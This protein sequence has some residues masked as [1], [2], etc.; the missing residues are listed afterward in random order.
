MKSRLPA[1]FMLTLVLLTLI[2]FLL[3]GFLSIRI[4]EARLLPAVESRTINS[5]LGLQQRLN[6]ALAFSGNL[7]SLRG[8]EETLDATR[9]FSPG[10]EF[11]ALTDPD[12]TILHLSANDPGSVAETLARL[13][14]PAPMAMADWLF[15]TWERITGRPL[16]SPVEMSGRRVGNLLLSSL[17]LGRDPGSPVGYL[18]AGVTIDVIDA[19]TR[20]I[21]FDIVTVVIAVAIVAIEILILIYAVLIIRPL[22]MID[23]LTKRLSVKDLRFVPAS[24]WGG[25][26]QELVRMINEVIWRGIDVA[27]TRAG[28]IGLLLPDADGPRPIQSPAVSYIRLPLFVFFLSE[29]ILRPIL[30]QFLGQFAPPDSDAGLRIGQIMAGFMA[31]SLISVL[32]G[33]ILAERYGV[34]RIFFCGALLSAAGIAGH[35][36]AQGFATI[37]L[38]R[39]LTGFGYGLVYAAAQIYIS[40]H[41]KLDR[42]SSGFSVFFA[43]VVA[44]EICGPAL[45]GVL[46]DRLGLASALMAATVVAAISALLCTLLIS[47][48]VPEL[49]DASGTPGDVAEREVEHAGEAKSNGDA[50]LVGQTNSRFARHVPGFQWDAFRTILLNPRFM[51][52]IVC[53]AI[54]SK[55]L[56]TGGLFFLMPLAVVASGGSA[57]DSARVIMAYG[58]AILLLAPIMSPLADRWPK[59][60]L[61]VAVGCCVAGIGLV[62]PHAWNTLGQGGLF[63]LMV[64]TLLFGVGQT[65][66]IPAQISYLMRVAETRG[67]ETSAGAVLGTYRFIE[68]LGSLFGPLVA[69]GLLLAST[70]EEAL[71]LMGIAAVLLMAF[72]LSWYL[73]FGDQEEGDAIRALLFET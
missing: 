65:L 2:P 5:G 67:S 33:S 27:K 13:T 18:H 72:G 36:A 26:M 16:F 58:I 10:M 19:L 45:G 20:D 54:P 70:P 49:T 62:L 63:V 46:A 28:E 31:A 3:F 47:R 39:S 7:E 21:W 24:L 50:A 1:L 34:R 59:Y 53:F 38:S 32:F 41:A 52:A 11:L 55:A 4:F 57:P 9:S 23:F 43:V 51:V 73:A 56:L 6:L 15:D 14:D 22:W 42:R 61:W 37:L 12:G 68:R 29:A 25:G 64:A 60:Y 8:V 35:L 30:P 44:A 66:S 69:S 71:M 17:P 40:Q 48:S